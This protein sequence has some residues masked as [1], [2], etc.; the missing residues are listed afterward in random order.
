MFTSPWIKIQITVV[1][2]SGGACHSPYE[3]GLCLKFPSPMLLDVGLTLPKKLLI[4]PTVT[5]P[6]ALSG[7]KLLKSDIYTF[8]LPILH[9]STLSFT[10]PY[11]GAERTKAPPESGLYAF[12]VPLGLNL[13]VPI[14]LFLK[15]TITFVR[16]LILSPATN[17]IRSWVG[18]CIGTL[19]LFSIITR[20]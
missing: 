5:Q 2:M 19:C 18:C 1:P 17:R 15:I 20:K 3:D 16:F 10:I 4:Y 6:L 12:N 11:T 13:F 14:Y 7:S 8:I 9:E